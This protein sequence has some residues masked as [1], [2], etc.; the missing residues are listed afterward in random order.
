[1]L[2]RAA[3][4]ATQ[5][6]QWKIEYQRKFKFSETNHCFFKM[7]NLQFKSSLLHSNLHRII[8]RSFSSSK[9]IILLI[10]SDANSFLPRIKPR[11]YF[12]NLRLQDKRQPGRIPLPKEFPLNRLLSY[13]LVQF[14]KS[15][16]ILGIFLEL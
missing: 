4:C 16:H 14:L 1:M 10:T 5:R 11:S 8:L 9:S 13:D 6:K 7:S 12:S 2:R 15:Q 3:I